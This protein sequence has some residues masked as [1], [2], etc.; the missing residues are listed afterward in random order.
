MYDF[1]GMTLTNAFNEDIY[2]RDSHSH[3]EK[4]RESLKSKTIHLRRAP[5]LFFFPFLNPNKSNIF[6]VQVHASLFHC[7]VY[8][9][10][11]PFLFPSSGKTF[12]FCA[13]VIHEYIFV[14]S[15][16]V[17]GIFLL[18]HFHTLRID[19]CDASSMV[20]FNCVVPSGSTMF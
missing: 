9:V 1:R 14:F 17:E 15:F 4:L 2:W 6:R 18:P 7:P 8:R 13:S 3:E 11:F 10:C 5:P 20:A 16:N 19:V 12:S